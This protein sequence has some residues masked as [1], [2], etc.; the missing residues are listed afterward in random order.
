MYHVMY[1]L[2]TLGRKK[3]PPPERFALKKFDPFSIPFQV[4]VVAQDLPLLLSTC[5]RRRRLL[6]RTPISSPI[7]LTGSLR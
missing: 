1:N 4:N 3:P 2:S 5:R 7:N 6:T